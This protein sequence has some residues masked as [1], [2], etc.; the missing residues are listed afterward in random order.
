MISAFARAAWMLNDS[1]Y[2]T[3]ATRAARFVLREM[4]DEQGA[5]LRTYK[6]QRRS[7]AAFLDDYAFM[8][9]AS[10]DLYEAT[11]DPQWFDR[12][13]ELQAH[14]DAQYLDRDAGGYFMTAE[15]GEVLLVREKPSYDGAVPSGNSVAALNLL[16]L[17]SFTDDDRMRERAEALFASLSR[18][19]V[20]SPSAFA[21]LLVALDYYYD[22]PLEIAIIAKSDILE[23]AP[24]MLPLRRTFVPNKV[25]CALSASAARRQQARIPWLEAK[26]SLSDK[27][28]A[29]VCERGRCELPTSTPSAF[30]HQIEK[31]RPYPSYAEAGPPRLSLPPDR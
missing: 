11:G 22:V 3:L 13:V 9:A 17:S 18:R 5:L 25:F 6:D 12:A 27:P 10:L 26:R 21:Q 16:R 19:V 29:Y 1:R 28:T 15:T 2:L 4:R 7:S 23:A 24:L 14:Q 8:I 31:R 30:K 20:R